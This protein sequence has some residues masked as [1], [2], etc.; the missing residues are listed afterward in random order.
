MKKNIV[1]TAGFSILIVISMSFFSCRKIDT[2][3][4]V[5]DWKVVSLTSIYTY[6]NEK[7][8]TSFDGT[9][10]IY[11][12]YIND[13]VVETDTYTGAIYTDYHNDGT[14]VYSETFKNNVSG[15]TQTTGIDGHWYFTDANS[16]ANWAVTDLLAMQVGK[17]TFNTEIGTSY[18]TIYQGNNTLDI[19]EISTLTKSKIVLKMQKAE[20]LNFTQFVTT[21]EYT[22][23]PR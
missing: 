3:K 23:E 14:Y 15:I 7:F 5:G 11:N 10:K 9:T 12:H 8:E 21:L 22:L 18:S 2:G 13:T 17:Y 20:T 19:Y 16:E 4:L 1:F 6:N